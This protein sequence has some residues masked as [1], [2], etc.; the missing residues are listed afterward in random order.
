MWHP[1]GPEERGDCVLPPLTKRFH[2]RRYRYSIESKLLIVTLS[3]NSSSS[4]ASPSSI[5]FNMFALGQA[6]GMATDLRIAKA[7]LMAGD[8]NFQASQLHPEF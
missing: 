7:L 1:V 3:S 8:A 5:S 6:R 4:L 2:S